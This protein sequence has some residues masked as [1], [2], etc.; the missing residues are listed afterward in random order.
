MENIS[1]IGL[2]LGRVFIAQIFLQ[3]GINKIFNFSQTAQF[4]A[5]HGMHAV[6]MWLVLAILFELTGTALLIAGFFTR[7]G[8]LLLIMFM[9]PVTFVFHLD[10]AVRLQAIMFMKNIA[11]IGGLFMVLCTGPGKFS[12]DAKKRYK[13]LSKEDA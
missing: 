13:D 1:S 2:L 8:A 9:I 5:S 10:F 11:I 7:I 4:M 6:P 3:S 12:M